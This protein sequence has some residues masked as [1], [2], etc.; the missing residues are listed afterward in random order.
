[1]ASQRSIYVS[2]TF[3]D[4]EGHRAALK[5]ALE[6]GAGGALPAHRPGGAHLPAGGAGA[7]G[8]SGLHPHSAPA[9]RFG[10][11]AALFWGG[12]GAQGVR[13]RFSDDDLEP[14]QR[15]LRRMV[16]DKPITPLLALLFIDDVI[17]KMDGQGVLAASVPELMLG[18]V[19][20][21]SEVMPEAERRE[22]G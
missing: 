14:T 10:S 1:M 2:S 5:L 13:E 18:Y 9:D 11:A 7:A 16:G 3:A 12:V 15:Q 21:I 20:R 8:G 22:G 19:N 4:L 17:A 6:T